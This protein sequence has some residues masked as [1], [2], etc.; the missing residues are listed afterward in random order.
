MKFCGL[1]LEDTHMSV[2]GQFSRLFGLLCVVL[3]WMVRIGEA[4]QE[5][6]PPTPDHTSRSRLRR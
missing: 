1:G 6:N 3:S 2:P 4:A 5:R